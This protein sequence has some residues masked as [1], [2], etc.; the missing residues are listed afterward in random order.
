MNIIKEYQG[1]ATRTCVVLGEKLDEAHM[2]YGLVS[3]M[4]EYLNADP[5]DKSNLNEEIGD[6][7]FYVANYCTFKGFNFEELYNNE[8]QVLIQ[9]YLF[10]WSKLI[11]RIANLEKRKLAYKKDIPMEELKDLVNRLIYLMKFQCRIK[12]WDIKKILGTNIAKLKKRYPD[13]FKEYDALNRD[14]D[15]ELKILT[16]GASQ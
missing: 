16:D 10:E 12:G 13:G 9:G 3:E 14:L 5:T 7:F 4:E 11:G 2:I 6:A 1:L 8:Y 15:G